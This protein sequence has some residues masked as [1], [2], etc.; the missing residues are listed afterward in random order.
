MKFNLLGQFE[1]VADDGRSLILSRSKVSQLLGLLLIQNGE[2]VGVDSLIEE[3]WGEN[4]PR[5]ALTTLQTYVYHG[6][7]I[8]ASVPGGRDILITRPAGYSIRVPADTI[9]VAVFERLVQQARR[10]L[11]AGH[12]ETAAEHLDEAFRLWRGPVLAGMMTGPVLDAHLTYINELRF[13]A[14][15]LHIEASRRLGRHQEIIPWL[16]LLVAENPLNESLHAQLIKALHSCGRRAEALQA[17]RSLWRTLDVELGI[18]PAPELQILQH[19]LLTAR[20][21]VTAAR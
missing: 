4:V 10:A 6:R 7:K 1:M 9:D 8:F 18:E 13:A 11:E 3:L 5:S 2:T 20:T 19:D 14:N 17:Y 12:V 21:P 16:R 15:E